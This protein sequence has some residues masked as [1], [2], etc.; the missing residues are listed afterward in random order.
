MI[1]QKEFFQLKKKTK[2]EE[3]KKCNKKKTQKLT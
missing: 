3:I 2:Q 1:N